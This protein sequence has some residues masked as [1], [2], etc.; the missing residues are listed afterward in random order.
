MQIFTKVALLSAFTGL[1]GCGGSGGSD[2]PPVVV[3]NTPPVLSLVHV[4]TINEQTLTSLSVSATDNG[5]ISTYAWTQ[6][7]GVPVTLANTDSA[8][9]T[10]TSPVVL[11][12]DDGQQLLFEVAVTDNEQAVT[13]EQVTVTVNAVNA[14]PVISVLDGEQSVDEQTAVTLAITA[15]DDSAISSYAW[16]QKSGTPVT[17]VT[18]DTATATF[19]APV[20]SVNDGE[21]QLTFEVT[22][23]DNEDIVSIAQATVN[24]QPVNA[25]P[26]ATASVAAMALTGEN[27]ILTANG[28]DSDGSIATYQWQQ[29]SGSPVNLQDANTANAN[30]TVPDVTASR[31]VF[32][33]TV[34]DDELE[35]VTESAAII[36]SNNPAFPPVIETNA[37]VIGKSGGFTVIEWQLFSAD[38]PAGQID[39]KLEQLSGDETLNMVMTDEN[40][41]Y[42]TAPVT[43]ADTLQYQLKLIA[44]DA[45]GAVNEQQ[46]QLTVNA[47][48][49]SFAA[50]K[51]IFDVS[52]DGKSMFGFDGQDMDND[53]I[54]DIVA[55]QGDGL[56][57]YK[58]N[59]EL[60]IDRTS[61]EIFPR[62]IDSTEVL[63]KLEDINGDK[64]PDLIVFNYISGR[65]W[66][67]SYATNDG[68]GAFGVR[69]PIGI[70]T[71]AWSADSFDHD[72]RILTFD[73]PSS[74]QKSLIVATDDGNTNHM[75]IFN[76]NAQGQYAEATIVSNENKFLQ[77]NHIAAC[78]VSAA[79][80]QEIFYIAT[81][82]KLG[83]GDRDTFI[84]ALSKQDNYQTPYLV[85]N[86]ISG[87]GGIVCLSTPNQLDSL[88]HLFDEQ[89]QVGTRFITYDHSSADYI[90]T[91]SPYGSVLNEA[92]TRSYLYLLATMDVDNDGREDIVR[93][94]NGA[95]VDIYYRNSA[96]HFTY[97]YQRNFNCSGCQ[98]VSWSEAANYRAIRKVGNNFWLS[99]SFVSTGNFAMPTDEG[100]STVVFKAV[101]SIQDVTASNERVMV[102]VF[103]GNTELS[104]RHF[105]LN[106]GQLIADPDL[107]ALDGIR[108]KYADVNGNGKD[109]VIYISKDPESQLHRVMVRYRQENG[110][111]ESTVLA[112]IPAEMIS[113]FPG[114]RPYLAR[115]DAI[116]DINDDGKADFSVFFVDTDFEGPRRWWLSDQATNT[117]TRDHDTSIFDSFDGS[118]SYSISFGDFNHDA[119]TDLW[120]INQR[121][122]CFY[123]SAICGSLQYRLNLGDNQ[124]TDWL[125]VA[126]NTQEYMSFGLYDVNLDGHTEL[127][128]TSWVDAIVNPLHVQSV[129]YRYGD[130]GSLTARPINSRFNY[131]GYLFGTG[132]ANFNNFL[133]AGEL[134][135][136]EFNEL[137][138]LPV[139]T[140]VQPMPPLF[141]RFKR[142][143][144]DI[145]GDQDVDFI[146]HDN[147][148]I[149]LIEN[150]H[151]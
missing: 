135:L 72:F 9:A 93:F 51:P 140:E 8:T 119:L 60:D 147:R 16:T 42:F 121:T 79:D 17:L 134:A 90:K 31:L 76:A 92:G 18:A 25:A 125:S 126:E 3:V 87:D 124:Y 15:T 91:A 148:Q 144:A 116:K 53:G 37:E 67:L 56:F 101:E 138:E 130:D 80:S 141:S 2:T 84:Y 150:I 47:S 120:R 11:S 14:A 117:Y 28:S 70:L 39:M 103:A 40:K 106:D 55:S 81:E 68:A 142:R 89:D 38:D 69:Q 33:V 77:V 23:T 127:V 151:H 64:L 7:S 66:Q 111:G 22:V 45:Q 57:W 19:A 82:Q 43:L 75:Y 58:N 123:S 96:D 6:K 44:T 136:F 30:F 46:I 88:A 143:M 85:H 104:Y 149:Y 118:S 100:G 63:A 61:R 145:D 95:L 112:E 50:A 74:E 133:K 108:V 105:A 139:V 12:N 36:V 5:S 129:W 132:E 41:A 13:T 24:V 110:F 26:T 71:G 86:A 59:G 128:V 34:A 54:T 146:Q 62:P 98:L 52:N 122:S 113:P 4:L 114:G 10:F 21:Q 137:I 102:T 49:S 94:R 20:V 48:E 97:E 83:T 29:I 32:S 115:L 78:N 65:D 109:D 107:A 99:D 131:H 73:T 27:V 35:T 1:Y